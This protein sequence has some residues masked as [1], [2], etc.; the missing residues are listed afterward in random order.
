MSELLAYKVWEERLGVPLE[1]LAQL[2]HQNCY[3]DG[4][5]FN[6]LHLAF[7]NQEGDKGVVIDLDHWE[8]TG[9][10]I[11]LSDYKTKFTLGLDDPFDIT[12]ML[13]TEENRDEK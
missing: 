4:K 12:A 6:E 11:Y 10:P 5:D 13:T 3:Y 9:E 2:I 7:I 1:V 8:N